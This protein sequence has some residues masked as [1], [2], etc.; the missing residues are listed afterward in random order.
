MGH[1]G[2]RTHVH[3]WIVLA[4]GVL[5][6]LAREGNCWG[7]ASSY[8]EGKPYTPA[9]GFAG[10]MNPWRVQNYIGGSD[11]AVRVTLEKGQEIASLVPEVSDPGYLIGVGDDYL[12]LV[13]PIGTRTHI[14]L[15]MDIP[16]YRG[17]S[18]LPRP[19][20]VRRGQHRYRRGRCRH[21]C[22]IRCQ[23]LRGPGPAKFAVPFGAHP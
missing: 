16:L 7:V 4:F 8:W 1:L 5:L 21:R 17:R 3:L 23:I 22:W 15:D 13:V 19:R 6:A 14:Y 12:D 10:V 20:K 18:F 2:Q 11:I 9:A